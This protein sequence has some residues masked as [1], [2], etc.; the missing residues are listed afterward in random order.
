MENLFTTV[1][2]RCYFYPLANAVPKDLKLSILEYANGQKTDI[3]KWIIHVDRFLR[4][5]GCKMIHNY[6]GSN[7]TYIK[8]KTSVT[9]GYVC[10]IIMGITGCFIA[11]GINHLSKSNNILNM[12]PDD[13][14]DM[15]ISGMERGQFN[16]ELCYRSSGNM[17]FAR[18][19]LMYNGE[20]FEGCRHTGRCQFSGDKCRFI[21]FNFDLADPVVRELMMKWIEMELAV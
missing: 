18:F 7:F 19:S 21:G 8:R 4:N 15:I 16:S 17:G 13:M 10:G 3:K 6:N 1:F 5:N 14:V 9:D 11:P 20:E 12:L 2:L